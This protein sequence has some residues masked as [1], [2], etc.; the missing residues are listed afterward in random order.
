MNNGSPSAMRLAPC[1]LRALLGAVL[2]ALCSSPALAGPVTTLS[3]AGTSAWTN[4]AAVALNLPG[5][6]NAFRVTDSLYRGA[7]PK[8]QGFKELE[9]LG[10]RTV[11]SL[12]DHHSDK[13]LL[14]GT[15]LTYIEI[16][17]DTWELN[18]DNVVAFLAIASDTNN[19][20]LFVHCQHGADRTGTMV[21]SYRMIVC[22]WEKEDA[23]DEMIN[24]G[25]GFHK[26][27]ENLPRF[28]NQLDIDAVRKK[29][30]SKGDKR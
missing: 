30:S 3:A 12:R 20:P 11:V 26:T 23:I 29:I 5:L 7:Q 28:L 4:Q 6:P 17:I 27:W 19:L 2:L 18:E 24:G 10:V 21:A 13:K 9:K 15:S 8:A 1:P 25:F 22:G 14:H 16:G